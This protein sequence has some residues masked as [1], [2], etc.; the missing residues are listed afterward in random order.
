M[1]GDADATAA[2]KRATGPFVLRRL[3]TDKSIISD[4]PEKNEMKVWCTLTAEQATLY[5]AVVEDMMAVDREQRGHPAPRQR[6][7]PR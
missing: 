1:R 5:Q 4:L 6:A 2:L 7:S 3:K